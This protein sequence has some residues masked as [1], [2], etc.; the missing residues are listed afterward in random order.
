MKT[1]GK[2][3]STLVIKVSYAQ[4]FIWQFRPE[5][6]ENSDSCG[7]LVSDTMN[8]FLINSLI[9]IDYLVYRYEVFI[10]ILCKQT[11]EAKAKNGKPKNK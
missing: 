5:E 11:E 10:E 2:K 6:K 8:K 9:V 4:E 3:K 1:T 7:K